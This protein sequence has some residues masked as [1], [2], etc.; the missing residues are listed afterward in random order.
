L[1]GK[2]LAMP[3]KAVT[4]RNMDQTAIPDPRTGKNN[5]ASTK[6]RNRHPK[7]DVF[8]LHAGRSR[9]PSRWRSSSGD[10]R[11]EMVS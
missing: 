9:L 2:G 11:F 7:L 6:Q 3:Y 8:E 1:S 5:G 4:E 10:A